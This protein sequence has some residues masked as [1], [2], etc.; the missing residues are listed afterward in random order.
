MWAWTGTLDSG[1]SEFYKWM[2]EGSNTGQLKIRADKISSGQVEIGHEAKT[3]RLYLSKM[4]ELVLMGG[5]YKRRL[6]AKSKSLGN[7]SLQGH[8]KQFWTR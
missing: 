2:M 6:Y 3:N 5:T 4:E 1:N 8:S 7:W